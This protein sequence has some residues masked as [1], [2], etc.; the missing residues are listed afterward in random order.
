MVPPVTKRLRYLRR[1]MPR[2]RELVL[3]ALDEFLAPFS[4]DEL[5]RQGPESR[6]TLALTFDDGPSARTTPRILDLLDEHGAQGTFFVVGERVAG[7][8][9]VLERIAAHGHELANHTFR[10]PHTAYLSREE[11]R[12]ELVATNDA[13]A[14]AAPAI[15]FARPPYGKDRRRFAAVAAELGLTVAMWSVDSG[16]ATGYPA[17]EIVS[18]VTRAARP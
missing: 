9:E 13:I 1:R 14:S 4:A 17:S 10:H 2:P 18:T 12:R 3:R 16:D 15:R 8:E 5:V 6:R 7:A 11:I